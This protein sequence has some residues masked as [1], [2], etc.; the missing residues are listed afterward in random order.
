MIG[1]LARGEV[2]G[3]GS[4]VPVWHDLEDDVLVAIAECG[5]E[6]V[7]GV[8]GAGPVEDHRSLARLQ[9]TILAY[10]GVPLRG[11][12]HL[13]RCCR[14]ALGGGCFYIILHSPGFLCLSASQK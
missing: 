7:G 2:E 13:Q 3:H 5:S 12:R 6:G 4:N 8:G 9:E 1:H 10:E 11:G 14:H